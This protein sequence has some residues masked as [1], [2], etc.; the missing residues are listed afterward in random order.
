MRLGLIGYGNISRHL[1][2]LLSGEL[3]EQFTV[4][5]RPQALEAAR[6]QSRGTGG[7][8][9]IEF[10]TSREALQSAHPDLVVECAGQSAVDRHVEP[11]LLA[12][13]DCLIVSVGALADAEL[14][15]RLTLAAGRGASR[16][17]LP[18]GAIGGLDL[19]AALSSA[20][21]VE[22][23]YRGAKPPAAWKATPAENHVRHD[24]LTAPTTFF[25]GTAR[26]AAR[27]FPQN[28][29]V[30][31]ALALAGPGFEGISVELIADPSAT[32]NR[33]SYEV[34]SPIC[35]YTVDIENAASEG[36]A[37]TST[38]TV[39]SLLHEIRS[40][41]AARIARGAR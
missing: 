5:V 21:S 16:M 8:G 39:F 9:P 27:L 1:V 30:V 11:L 37:R 40:Y 41:A 34:R 18:C 28:A 32:G 22:V 36:N 13:I 25:T 14:H 26:E 29:N 15:D 12:G 7:P 17:I 33:H 6:A 35:S 3:T 24:G 23:T 10:V 38:A 31:A 2:R 20:G 4:Q 19:L